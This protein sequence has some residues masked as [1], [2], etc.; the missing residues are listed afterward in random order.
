MT[1]SGKS[2]LIGALEEKLFHDIPAHKEE[3]AGLAG[4]FVRREYP[5]KKILVMAGERWD[6]A[7]FI[8]RG[9]IRLY[10]T[11]REGREFN[12]DFFR[13][14]QLLWPV[15]PSAR[16]NDSLFSIAAVEDI[17]VSVCRFAS[18]H[19]WLADHSYWEK[20]ALPYAESFAEEKFLR[21]YEFLMN[22]AA[23]RFQNFCVRHPGLA[24]RIPDYH[25][26]SYLGITNVS[27]SRIKKSVDFN[28]C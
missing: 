18:F 8:H 21:E 19:S 7:F 15:A 24:R 17:K 6:R 4:L 11:D 2:Y 20:F 13:E 9:I 16:K 22:P 5:R 23:K 3:L 12:K 26:A 14:G 28:L 1:D 25:L 10:Y 27:L